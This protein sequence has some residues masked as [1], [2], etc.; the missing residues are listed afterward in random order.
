MKLAIFLP[1]W[2][3]DAVMAT[4]T[5]RALRHAHRGAKILGIMPPVIADVLQGTDFFDDVILHQ[6]RGNHPDRSGHAVIRRLRQEQC[7][8]GV[9]LPNSWRSAWLAWRGGV[10]RR[11]GFGRDGRGI[12]LTDAL[13]SKSRSVPNPVLDQYLRLADHLGCDIRSKNTELAVTESDQA[14]LNQFW[15]RQSPELRARGVVCFNT[16]GA[17]GPAK[18]WPMEYFASLAQR[19]VDQHHKT[20]LIV[21][22]PSERDDAGMIARESGRAEVLTLAEEP[23]SVGLTKAAIRDSELLVTTDSGPRHFAQPFRVPV[24]TL[25]GPT[26]IAWS[27]THYDLAEHLQVSVDCGPCQ[28]RACPRGHHRCLRD[29]KVDRVFASVNRILAP[30]IL[31]QRAA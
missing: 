22:G 25:F 16:G 4:P 27:E 5:L 31:P 20:V 15:T 8:L 6:P 14:R 1:N 12:L 17:F 2:V 13:K 26:H 10:R 23:L 7:D 21:C 9:L 3:G 29:L 18:N 19:I 24:I 11:V 28:Q 30:R